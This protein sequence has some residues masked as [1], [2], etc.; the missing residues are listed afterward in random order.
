MWSVR[1]RQD[2]PYQ[3]DQYLPT[4]EANGKYDRTYDVLL[5]RF[6]ARS[7]IIEVLSLEKVEV[8]N[9]VEIVDQLSI[10][11][12]VVLVVGDVEIAAHQH[13]FQFY[14]IVVIIFSKRRRKT[15][16]CLIQRANVFAVHCRERQKLT[17]A[18]VPQ[19][20]SGVACEN[21]DETENERA[22]RPEEFAPD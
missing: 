6:R 4:K 19:D 5:R 15:R 22:Q 8:L 21:E 16:T 17:L 2:V 18:S 11:R 12:Q 1:C 14:T 13:R 3:G 9:V 10:V 7:S 20:L